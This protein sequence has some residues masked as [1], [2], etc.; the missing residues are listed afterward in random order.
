MCVF[1]GFFCIINR[2]KSCLSVLNY[3]NVYPSGN[4]NNNNKKFSIRRKKNERKRKEKHWEHHRVCN[5]ITGINNI[6]YHTRPTSILPSTAFCFYSG[7]KFRS[8]MS[9]SGCSI[10]MLQ[11]DTGGRYRIL[12]TFLYCIMS[13]FYFTS[14][15]LLF[16]SFPFLLSL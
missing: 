9:L 8:A 16:F 14:F 5:M 12:Q 1:H 11:L 15:A 4:N 13:S 6:S 3:K 7:N 2:R 10:S